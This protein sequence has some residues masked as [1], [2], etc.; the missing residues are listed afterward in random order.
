MAK[1]TSPKQPKPKAPRPQPGTPKND[2]DETIYDDPEPAQGE[3]DEEGE[4]DPPG[5]TRPVK[6]P[7]VP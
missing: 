1:A 7:P 5:S 4:P 2:P 6:P 3:E